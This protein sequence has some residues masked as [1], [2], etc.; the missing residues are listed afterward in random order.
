ML[1]AAGENSLTFFAGN[2]CACTE[3]RR[4]SGQGVCGLQRVAHRG[5]AGCAQGR[6]FHKAPLAVSVASNDRSS[7][8]KPYSWR[9]AAPAACAGEG[10][11]R[12]RC[13][14]LILAIHKP[15]EACVCFA[16]IARAPR[17]IVI[18][19]TTQRYAALWVP[20]V[21]FAAVLVL[22]L[23]GRARIASLCLLICCRLFRLERI[24]GLQDCSCSWTFS[25]PDETK[26]WKTLQHPPPS[27]SHLMSLGGFWT[28]LCARACKDGGA[29][30]CAAAMLSLLLRQVL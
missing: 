7:W 12:C 22:P 29:V 24:I 27:A 17:P 9:G 13:S 6:A 4:R 25:A 2:C 3:A 11:R 1:S 19:W 20:E 26:I 8:V 16:A 10:Y 14:S 21:H 23:Y 30:I 5:L 28:L 15:H 18:Q